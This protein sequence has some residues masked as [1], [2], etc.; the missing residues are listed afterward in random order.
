MIIAGVN[1]KGG[2]G[3]TTLIYNLAGIVAI[4]GKPV[5]ILDSDPQKSLYNVWM[6]CQENIPIDVIPVEEDFDLNHEAFSRAGVIFIDTP[7]VNAKPI[8]RA[9]AKATF[10]LVPIKPS[11]LDLDASLPL[12]E[13]AKEAQKVNPALQI[14]WVINQ[15]KK[16]TVVSQIIKQSAR[17]REC[18]PVADS[19]IP[20]TVALIESMLCG[21]PLCYYQAKHSAVDSFKELLKDINHVKKNR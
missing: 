1:R 9:L 7:P 16:G 10:V 15:V 4:C 5:T 12:A 6:R 13:M 17:E 3:K 2:S 20:D 18:L 11:P 21:I 8:R 14:L 19:V